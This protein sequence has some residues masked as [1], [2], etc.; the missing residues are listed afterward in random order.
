MKRSAGI[1]MY[2]RT[3]SD[4]LVLLVHP[5]G[6]FWSKKDEGAWSIP[7]GEYPEDEAAETAARREFAEEMG[8]L[9]EGKLQPLGDLRQKGGKRVTAFALEGE[10]DVATPSSNLFEIEWPPGSGRLQS[11]PEVDRAE[12]FTLSDARR[13]ILGSQLPFL[14]RLEALSLP[15]AQDSAG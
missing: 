7:K 6:P 5:G 9:P 11:F 13:K 3:Q 1:L 15:T 12:W 8:R 10:F 4:L 2:R 14:E